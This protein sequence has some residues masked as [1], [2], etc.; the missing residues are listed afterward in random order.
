MMSLDTIRAMSDDQAK[1]AARRG[2][3]PYVPF[4]AAEI[5]SYPPFPFPNI[6]S[7]RPK[8][9]ELIDEWFVDKSGWG[10]ADEPAMTTEQLKAALLAMN[11]AGPTYGYAIIEEGEFQ[12]YIG[13]FKKT[14]RKN[15]G[16]KRS[17]Q[18]N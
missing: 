16:S 11:N 12:L 3:R 15:N 8:G 13:I 5:D 10:A 2:S 6:G 14:E 4:N 7:Y 17:N 1:K 9:W 18:I